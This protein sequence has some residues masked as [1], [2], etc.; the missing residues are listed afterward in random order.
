M[1]GMDSH[2]HPDWRRLCGLRI[3]QH[4]AKSSR[5]IAATDAAKLSE[6]DRPILSRVSSC[7]PPGI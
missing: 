2:C 6:K 7:P 3:T 5:P 1:K 4:G